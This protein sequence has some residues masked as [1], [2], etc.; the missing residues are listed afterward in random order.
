MKMSYKML[1]GFALAF[2]ISSGAYGAVLSR[3]NVGGGVN[4]LH[5]AVLSR[6]NVGVNQ[7]TEKAARATSTEAQ[8]NSKTLDLNEG[9]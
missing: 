6:H 8:D 2:C 1:C 5:G 4:P 7:N 3:H 9:F